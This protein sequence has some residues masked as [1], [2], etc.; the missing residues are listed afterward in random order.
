MKFVDASGRGVGESYIPSCSLN[1][2]LQKKYGTIDTNAF[3]YYLQQN[4]EQVMKDL[5]PVNESN[6]KTCPVCSS[7]LSYK[8]TG[9]IQSKQ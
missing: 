2:V 6:C 3:R 5:Q 9:N 8:P 4:G 1:S 7:S